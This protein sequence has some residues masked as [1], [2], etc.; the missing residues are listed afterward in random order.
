MSC[1][2]GPQTLTRSE[3]GSLSVIATGWV[4]V[5]P[6]LRC[7]A[8]TRLP[9]ARATLCASTQTQARIAH[10]LPERMTS[11]IARRSVPSRRMSVPIESALR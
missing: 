10:I 8:Q 11:S 6:G 7:R 2:G 5:L 3:E 4:L 9:L 1:H